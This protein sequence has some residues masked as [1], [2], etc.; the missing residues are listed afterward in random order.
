M[1][2]DAVGGVWSYALTLAAASTAVDVMLA[3]LG[4]APSPAQRAA[5]ADLP[6]LRLVE[7]GFRLEWMEAPWA[8]VARAEAWLLDLA[9]RHRPD[10]VHVNGYAHAA[11]A[12]EA[13]VVIV[14]HSC[15]AS[16]WQAVHGEP[17]PAAWDEFRRRVMAGL[18]A[19]DAVVAPTR[20]MLTALEAHYGWRGDGRVIANGCDVGRFA[21]AS[22]EPFV[23]AAGRLWDEAKNLATLDRAAASLPWP[24]YVAG[25]CR[26]PERGLVVPRRARAL[27]QLPANS[28]AAWMERAA[29]YAS[30]ARYEPFGLSIL[31][32]ASAGCALVLGDIPSL[33]ELWEGAAL[34]APPTDADAFAGAIAAL[35]ADPPRRA[36][37]SARARRR[38]RDFPA[39][40]MARSYAALYD[41]LLCRAAAP[42][43]TTV[44]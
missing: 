40:R 23:M 17:A 43:L 7:G 37:L 28:L 30:P 8:D 42:A 39:A 22:K 1:T 11:A 29:I 21:P 5:A 10:I 13:P 12:W 15:V 25:N 34:F 33:R 16:W 19:A 4:P 24:V 3:V 2:A 31:E 20:A 32:A 18:R 6:N 38:A 14:A 44:R 9:A 27:G 36:A 35:I 26:H 41:E